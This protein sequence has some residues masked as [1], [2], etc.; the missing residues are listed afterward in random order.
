ML[1]FFFSTKHTYSYDTLLQKK[2]ENKSNLRMSLGHFEMNGF[3]I[4]YARTGQQAQ[5]KCVG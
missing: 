1:K 4:N 3:A 5:T 2:A